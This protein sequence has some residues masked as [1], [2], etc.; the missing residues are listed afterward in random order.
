MT[1]MVVGIVTDRSLAVNNN[2][3]LYSREAY[4]RERAR[5]PKIMSE[6]DKVEMARLAEHAERY[7]GKPDAF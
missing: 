7:E 5:L 1:S 4:E 6:Q 3:F 2:S